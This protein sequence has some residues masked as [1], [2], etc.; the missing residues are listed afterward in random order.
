[1]LEAVYDDTPSLSS[2]F[3]LC[4]LTLA[5]TLPFTRP[6]SSCPL[7]LF[8]VLLF[9]PLRALLSFLYFSCDNDACSAMIADL[10]LEDIQQ[11]FVGASRFEIWFYFVFL[12][13]LVCIFMFLVN[14]GDRDDDVGIEKEKERKRG[15][16]RKTGKERWRKRPSLDIEAEVKGCSRRHYNTRN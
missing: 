15:R 2:S 16:K 13:F 1:M 9:S 10:H 14:K 3:P 8:L 5:A 7:S 12:V 6:P 11:L 4:H